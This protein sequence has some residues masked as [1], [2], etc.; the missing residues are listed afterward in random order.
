M[1]AWLPTLLVIVLSAAALTEVGSSLAASK[2]RRLWTASILLVGSLAI[3]GTVW[4]ARKVVDGTKPLVGTTAAPELPKATHD[5]P[6][7]AD[8]T[9]QVRALEDR[10]SELE[11]RSQAR[12]ILPDTA[13]GLAA[14]LRQFGN[15][16]VVV[17][18]IPD[19]LEAYQYANRLVNILRAASWDA[20]GPELTRIFGD[21]RAPGINVYVGGNNHSDTAEIL[22]GG[23]TKFSIPFQSR[24]TPSEAIPDADT[25][26]LFVGTEQPQP[27][28]AH[29]N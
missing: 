19:D 1:L 22:L 11:A 16:R 17:S 23:F 25:V 10:I 29:A 28:S 7:A 4:Q 21:V 6:T 14:Y 2:N 15:R 18:C 5:E 27:A 9:K 8:L 13:E 20:R 24:V 26:E 12:T 3:A